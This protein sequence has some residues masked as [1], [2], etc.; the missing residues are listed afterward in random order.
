MREQDHDYLNFIREQACCICGNDVAVEAHHPRV[1]FL[2]EDGTVVDGTNPGAA[3]KASDR[4]ALPLCGRH[5]REAHAKGDRL[6]WAELGIDPLA[7]ALNYQIT[8][9]RK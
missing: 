8:A 9:R 1:G 2:N 3:Q 4:W 6:F 7:L 5:H